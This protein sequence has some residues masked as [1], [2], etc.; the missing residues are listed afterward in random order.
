MQLP[1]QLAQIDHIFSD[2]TGTL[3]KNELVFRGLSF[4][5]HRCEAQTLA[6]VI[7]QI[8]E[9]GSPLAAK[10]FACFCI[11]SDA[12]FVEI[13][14]TGKR[15]LQGP[16]QDELV[17]LELAA[18]ADLV[19]LVDRTQD[20]IVVKEGGAE[21]TYRIVK[22]IKFDPVRRMMTMVVQDSSGR[23][24]AFSKGADS[25]ILPRI[26]DQKSELYEKTVDHMESFAAQGMRTLVFAYKQIS[27]AD[28]ANLA[29]L[30]DECFETEMELLGCSGVED[31]LQDDV[32]KSITDFHEAG[33]R[34]WIVTGDKN[35]TARSIGHT[36][37][38]FMQG[39]EIEEV[40][41]KGFASEAERVELFARLAAGDRDL[42]ISGKAISAMIDQV[43]GSGVKGASKATVDA[44][45]KV[46]GLV[47]FRASPA[48][49]AKLVQLVRTQR[50]EITTLAIGDGANDVNMI[51]QAH[52]GIGIIG[53]E[54]SQASSYADFAIGQFKD[55]RRLLFWHGCTFGF[56][57]TDFCN[58]MFAKT[59]VVGTVGIFYNSE[60]G[61]SAGNFV[62]DILFIMYNMVNY[63]YYP[64]L[65]VN[66][67]KRY[68]QDNESKLPFK[69][70]EAYS[71]FRDVYMKGMM[72]RFFIFLVF[73]YFGGAS[74]FYVTY[75]SFGNSIGVD[76]QP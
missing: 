35:S 43:E 26:A 74:A 66:I 49:K 75:Y 57:L 48:E 55:L 41:D 46:R 42:L 70:S 18:A 17:L 4:G 44:M 7:A 8:K 2:K 61:W 45:L 6:E 52:V 22:H 20:S 40:G 12:Y 24:F 10:I 21:S 25:S 65:E 58:L 69:M 36:A 76:G 59:M 51:Q 32:K 60:A 28:Q 1:E 29:S 67:S 5:G 63:G 72:R 71:Y 14:G 33:I 56:S 30:P 34:T 53:K 47:V 37:G 50:P 73:S 31:L 13:Q 16:S 27:S 11:C 9:A 39:R 15:D 19:T 23:V 68:Y 38:V 62:E 3:T 54:G 64:F